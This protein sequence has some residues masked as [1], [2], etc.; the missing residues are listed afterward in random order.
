MNAPANLANIIVLPT[1]APPNDA[2]VSA[3][4]TMRLKFDGTD[5]LI[6]ETGGAYVPLVSL[7]GGGW[8]RVGTDVILNTQTDSVGMGLTPAAS[9]KVLMADTPGVPTPLAGQTLRVLAVGEA[10]DSMGIF[11]DRTRTGALAAAERISQIGC[12]A[13]GNLADDASAIVSAVAV[14]QQVLA[15][16]AATFSAYFVESDGSTFYDNILQVVDQPLTIRATQ[17][18]TG[19]GALV[20][21]VGSAAIGPGDLDG[22]GILLQA[23]AAVNAGSGGNIVMIAG[24]GPGNVPGNVQINPIDIGSTG[25]RISPPFGSVAAD[26][27]R[28]N[29]PVAA[30]TFVVTPQGLVIIGAAA[31]LGTELF[32]VTGGAVLFDA[33]TGVVPVAGAGTRFMWC[34]AKRAI[35]AGEVTG[36]EWDDASVGLHSAAFGIDTIASGADS[37]A[38]GNNS[39]ATGAHAVAMGGGC[40]AS[41]LDATAFGG[42]ANAGGDRAFAA[43]EVCIASGPRAIALGGPGIASGDTSV[44][45][46]SRSFATGD[47]QKAWAGG[48]FTSNGDAQYV[49]WMVRNITTDGVETELFVDGAATRMVLPDNATWTFDML[50]CARRTDAD[51]EGAGYLVQ[52]VI[53]R[54]VGVAT[55]ALIGAVI[56][57]ILGED[58]AGWDVVVSADAG[59][60]S[61]KVAGLGEAAKTIRWTAVTR[62]VQVL[63]A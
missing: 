58:V 32:R 25:L 6:S 21:I 62:I 43:G 22:S 26:M 3:A 59:N 61:L 33:A 24:P 23:G 10:D 47:F 12:R 42:A 63:K 36:V 54:N 13:V 20:S 7:G 60:G 8:I 56:E 46:G 37:L 52:G 1:V 51:D 35:R 48:R 53:D 49:T 11:A 5:L 30:A 34:P 41:G 2:A 45:L 19:A 27:L 44:A 14:K 9:E 55:T 15:G 50:I 39:D 38:A 16:S 31:V 4:G 18:A 29:D 40:T 28:C 57:T 17:I